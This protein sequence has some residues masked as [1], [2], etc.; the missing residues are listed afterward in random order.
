MSVERVQRTGGPVWRVRWRDEQGR[1]RSRVVGRKADADAL[2]QKLKRSKRLGALAPVVTSHETVGEFA[3]LWWARYVVPNLALH[4]QLA[5]ASMLDVHIIPRI[6][7]YQL[8]S[9]TAEVLRDLRAD[10]NAAG[11]GDAA[12]RKTLVVIQS[13]LARAVEWRHI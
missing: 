1:A 2:D 13:M 8:R 6:G 7:D 10:M 11:T 5:Y 3:K 9:L 12:T 4:T